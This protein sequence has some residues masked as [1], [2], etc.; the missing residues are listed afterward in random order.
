MATT[1]ARARAS[2]KYDRANTRQFKLKLNT[3]TDADIIAKLD[4]V[5][6]KQ[7]YVKSLIRR[8]IEEGR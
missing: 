2:A 6:S 7:G 8:D 5:E 3:K 4:S 1:D